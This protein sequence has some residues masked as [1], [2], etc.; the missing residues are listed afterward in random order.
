MPQTASKRRC[1]YWNGLHLLILPNP[2]NST[3]HCNFDSPTELFGEG[4][5]GHDVTAGVDGVH[6]E[7]VVPGSIFK[8]RE[9]R[10]NT[11]Q[12]ALHHVCFKC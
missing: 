5:D 8:L 2:L 10:Q 4:K 3:F 7:H 11:K 6:H 1:K 12:A 9:R